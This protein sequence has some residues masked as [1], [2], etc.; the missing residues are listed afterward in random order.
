MEIL[1]KNREGKPVSYSAI[2]NQKIELFSEHMSPHGVIFGGR[3]LEIVNTYAAMVAEKHSEA[4]SKTS[5]INFVRFFSQAKRGD[6][7]ICKSSINRAWETCME[8]GVKV[9]AEDFL[10]LEHKHILS[11]YFTFEAY[12]EDNEVIQIA[13]VICETEDQRRR[14]VEAFGRKIKNR[15]FQ[16][17]SHS[18]KLGK[19]PKKELF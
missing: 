17:I 10:T 15:K 7:L 9:E 13:H 3:I 1:Q 12:N 18:N 2:E 11:A 5:G 4:K 19:P 16:K 14:Y 8:V 6:I